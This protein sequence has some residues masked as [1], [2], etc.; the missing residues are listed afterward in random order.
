[1]GQ[2][3][4]RLLTGAAPLSPRYGGDRAPYRFDVADYSRPLGRHWMA[5]YWTS[6]RLV[7]AQP[8]VGL[9]DLMGAFGKG[10]AN[11]ALIVA[12]CFL[13]S[14]VCREVPESERGLFR[15]SLPDGQASGVPSQVFI[16]CGHVKQG[17]SHSTPRSRPK[18]SGASACTCS[19]RRQH[20]RQKAIE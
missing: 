19:T 20:R 10:D 17:L 14:A 1:M 9:L 7:L 11:R 16:E 13:Q 3:W 5:A 12:H 6:E 8:L 2:Y 4:Q 18:R 15:P